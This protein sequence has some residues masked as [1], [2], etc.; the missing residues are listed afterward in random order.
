MCRRGARQEKFSD[1]AVLV[2]GALHRLKTIINQN[3]ASI[4][5]KIGRST[6]DTFHEIGRIRPDSPTHARPAAFRR[7]RSLRYTLAW[8]R[9]E[10]CL[11]EY[12][13]GW[14]KW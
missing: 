14:L 3:R 4:G 5:C 13:T 6:N 9:I 1:V 12:T 2:A 10:L 7:P 8:N 11:S